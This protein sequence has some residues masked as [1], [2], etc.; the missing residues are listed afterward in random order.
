MR[1]H[2]QT[3]V[4]ARPQAVATQKV[5]TKNA[6]YNEAISLV[7]FVVPPRNDETETFR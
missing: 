7:C 6:L 1:K 2:P 3:S 5:P 4:I